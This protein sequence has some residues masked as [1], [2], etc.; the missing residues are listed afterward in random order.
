MSKVWLKFIRVT[1]NLQQLKQYTASGE[2][3]INI[4]LKGISYY[5]ISYYAMKMLY[6]VFVDVSGKI[7]K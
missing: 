3:N 7:K 1:N 6:F 5:V 2:I 4:K